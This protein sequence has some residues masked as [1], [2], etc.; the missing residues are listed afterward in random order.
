MPCPNCQ[1]EELRRYLLTLMPG[2]SA[3]ARNTKEHT[4][5]HHICLTTIALPV[6][7]DPVFWRCSIN[8]KK[9]KKIPTLTQSFSTTTQLIDIAHAF[10]GFV[11]CIRCVSIERPLQQR[12]PLLYTPQHSPRGW[13]PP[14]FEPAILTSYLY[15]LR[16][17]KLGVWIPRAHGSPITPNPS[18]HLA[19]DARHETNLTQ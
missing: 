19:A 17:K 4:H 7:S 8:G 3:L 18:T 15:L 5:A 9:K 14:G 1:S 11:A 6:L 10:V 12:M 13:T 2:P 16:P